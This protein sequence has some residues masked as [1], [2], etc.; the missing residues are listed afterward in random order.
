VRYKQN[1]VEG[2]LTRCIQ[3]FLAVVKLRDG[4]EVLAHWAFGGQLPATNTSLNFRVLLSPAT[5]SRARFSYYVEILYMGR[6]A[7]GVHPGRAWE[8]FQES[9]YQNKLPQLAG[10]AT[11]RRQSQSSRQSRVH[12]LLEG[13]GLRSC[14]VHVKSLTLAADR[15][16]YYPDHLIHADT[17]ELTELTNAVRE[18]HRATLFFLVQRSDVDLFRPGDHIHSDY[19]SALRDTLARGV[20]L[21]VYRCKLTR[22]GIELGSLIPCDLTS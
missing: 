1:L 21:L 18:G 4:Q 13:N 14:H 9:I 16:T 22:K 7:I 3:K 19:C 6:I 12:Y 5:H 15:T 17:N 11:L 2:R 10:Y 20:E 8:I